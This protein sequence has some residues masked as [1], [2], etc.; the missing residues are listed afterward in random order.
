MNNIPNTIHEIYCLPKPGKPDPNQPISKN[1]GRVIQAGQK[2]HTCTYYALQ[3]LRQDNRIGKHPTTDSQKKEREVEIKV[4]KH[5]KCVTQIDETL[6][7]GIS[8][9]MEIAEIFETRACDKEIIK[10]MLQSSLEKQEEYPELCAVLKDFCEQDKYDDIITFAHESYCLSRI[11]VDKEFLDSFGVTQEFIESSIPKLIKKNWNALSAYEKLLHTSSLVF[12]HSY[13]AYGCQRSAWHPEDPIEKLIDQIQQHGAHL[14]GGKFR[15][16]FYDDCSVQ[17]ETKIQ[18][19]PVFSC[20]SENKI[21]PPENHCIVIVGVESQ[22][23]SVYFLDPCD[24]SDPNDIE[25]QKIHKI[26]YEELQSSITNLMGIHFVN[27]EG[28]INYE[29]RQKGKSNNYAI[30]LNSDLSCR[31]T[32]VVVQYI[33]GLGNSLHLFGVGGKGLSWEKGIP[34]ESL[35]D[36]NY[37]T[38]EL[39][40]ISKE[41]IE[42]KVVLINEE[43]KEKKWE[44]ISENNPFENRKFLPSENATVT[45]IHKMQF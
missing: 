36:G 1:R 10:Q 45:F 37:W 40:H 21:N 25:T 42:C 23:N 35:Y 22:T 15:S 7:P 33:A 43:N 28:K 17:L 9:A 16:E 34:L 41:P 24:R 44:V 13:L 27:S 31:S 20:P 32:R 39:E 5:R 14:V 29:T 8:T 11:N 30:Y 3:M 19:R 38:C 12:T 2:G 26:S 18:G 4:S 6:R